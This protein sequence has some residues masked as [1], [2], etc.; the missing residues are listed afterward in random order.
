M[1][2]TRYMREDWE[3]NESH[4]GTSHIA[5]KWSVNK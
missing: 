5:Q 2:I 1:T 4:H 3:I